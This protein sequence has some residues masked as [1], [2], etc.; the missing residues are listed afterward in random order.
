MNKKQ[1]EQLKRV[2]RAGHFERGRA[3]CET[4]LWKF[5]GRKPLMAEEDEEAPVRLV[6]ANTLD[7]ALAHMRRW[8]DGFEIQSV[9][10]LGIIV[11]LSGSPYH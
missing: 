2:K 11:L 6:A 7:E 5:K 9:K 8:E 3:G 1:K 4:L 10:S